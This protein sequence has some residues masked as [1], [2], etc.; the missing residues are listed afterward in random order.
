MKVESYLKAG[1]ANTRRR[2]KSRSMGVLDFF[3]LMG[4]MEWLA[5]LDAANSDPRSVDAFSTT[6]QID[7]SSVEA[8]NSHYH[9]EY[10]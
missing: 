9:E 3:L 2:V 5:R 8:N 4:M 10:E 1:F 7:Q 6:L